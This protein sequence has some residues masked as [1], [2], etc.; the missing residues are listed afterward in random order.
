MLTALCLSTALLATQT[1]GAVGAA[2]AAGAAGTTGAAG[3]I[4][5]YVSDA[6][7]ATTGAGKKAAAEWIQPAAF[8]D[9]VKKCVKE[10]SEPVFVTEDNRI[11]KFDAAS[12]KK[13]A[14]FHGHKV[15]VVGTVQG[16]TLSVDSVTGL[17]LQ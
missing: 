5:G 14:A 7:C 13:I 3:A 6:K 4:V 9:C 10:G 15:S 1:L 8:E 16:T 2:G 17:K 12:M 11:L